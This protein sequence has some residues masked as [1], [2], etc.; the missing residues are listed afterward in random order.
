MIMI[1]AGNLSVINAQN[2]K[3]VP[4]NKG[5]AKIETIKKLKDGSVIVNTT[6]IGKDIRGFAKATPLEVTIKK[7]KIVSVKPLPNHE[8]PEY[9]NLL[10]SKGFFN[11]WNGMTL[12]EVETKK[13]DAVS[14]A[15]FSSKA[16]IENVKRAAATVKK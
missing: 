1:M 13:V 14:G 9:F 4:E 12:K 15:T 8:T 5:K 6:E 7:G 11:Q 10:S 2:K 16:V 3:A